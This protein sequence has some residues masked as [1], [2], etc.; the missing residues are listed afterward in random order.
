[1]ATEDLLA[2]HRGFQPHVGEEGLGHRRQQCHQRF[3]A[4][5]SLGIL[6]ELGDIQLQRDIAGKGAAA[7]VQRLHGQQHAP[8]VRMHDDRIG[9]L[10]L[11]DRAGR[12]TALHA[13]ARIFD[14]A[15]VGALAG[16]QALDADAQAL[17]VHHGEHR[18]QALVG[19]ADHPAD[20]AVEVH[21]AGRR[22]LDAHL[23]LDGAAGKR[24]AR[25]QRTVI[26]D[27][28][29]GHEEQRDAARTGRRIGQLGQH[30]VDDVLGQIVFA[31]GDEDLGTADL[32]AAVG[33][34]LGLGA[35]DAQ[36][37]AGMGLGQ[38]HRARPDAAVHVG[39][40]L[41]LERFAGM[42]IDG[43][44][45]AGRQHR[46]QAESQAGRI[47]HLLDL[48]GNR[49]GHPHAAICRIATDTHPATLGVQAIGVGIASRRGD[50]AIVPTAALFVAATVQWGDGIAGDLAGFLENR[51]GS[52]CVDDLGQRGQALPQR[53]RIEDFIQDKTHVAQ[54]CFVVSHGKT[55]QKNMSPGRVAAGRP[56]SLTEHQLAPE[57]SVYDQ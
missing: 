52:R 48:G 56:S 9:H 57:A 53:R 2:M 10:V 34:G 35:D 45:G 23:V 24:I 47:H 14:G 19:L 31:A 55:S 15:L 37:G 28:H 49:L 41:L 27:H 39:Q 8:H 32:V 42:G 25:T 13:F 5:A 7:F 36:V 22:R 6:A 44:A 46:I 26:V 50:R 3:G 30:Q 51:L 40:V 38:T 12:R 54:R 43:Q 18:R 4:L 1:M 16:G 21:H 17:V 11:C 33:L 20:G 29:L